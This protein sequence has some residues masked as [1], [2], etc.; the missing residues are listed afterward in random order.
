MV[1]ALDPAV[2]SVLW[3]AIYYLLPERVDDHPLGCH[4]QRVA[5]L[6]CFRGLLIRLVTGSSWE[7]VEALM[8]FKV[9]D[10]TLRA[11]RDE[12]IQA[13]VFDRLEAETRAGYDRIV[14]L[15]MA[16]VALDGSIHKAPC[17]GEGT[18]KSPV[19]RAKLGWK[20][21]VAVDANGIPIG[22]AV[23]GANRNDTRLLEPTLDAI[24]ANGLIDDVELLALDRGYDYPVIRTRLAGYGLSELE[25]QKRGTKPP[26]G[27][28]HRITLGL[29][30]IVEALNSW[31]SNYGQ[32][33]RSTDR[34]TCH[35]LAALSLATTVLMTGRLIDYRN[36]WSTAPTPTR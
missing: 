3:Q 14:G 20:W 2:I 28:P 19:D 4:R 5:D 8:E 21:S 18:G 35:R 27:T 12:W 13:G 11:R 23:D 36:R 32:L 15:D 10:T 7:T 24:V 31:W 1:R 9:S 17:G 30:W 16:F 34:K 22:V 33:R 25:I 29:R 6:V 26:P